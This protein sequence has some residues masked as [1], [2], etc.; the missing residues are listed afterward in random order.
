MDPASAK[1]F[2]SVGGNDSVLATRSRVRAVAAA[3]IE[4][5]GS[6][7]GA[8]ARREHL[9][10]VVVEL[11]QSDAK[12]ADRTEVA[13]MASRALVA[14]APKAGEV[15]RRTTQDVTS[16]RRSKTGV[17]SS[18][19]IAVEASVV[20]T[21]RPT[22]ASVDALSATLLREGYRVVVRER[23]ECRQAACAT[24]AIVE[25]NQLEEVPLGWCNNQICGLHCFKSCG[26]CK[27]VYLCTALNAAGKAPSVYCAVCE[28]VLIEWGASKVWTA[29]LV[30]RGG[31]A[32]AARHRLGRAGD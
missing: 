24:E 32:V 5:M 3:T 14:Y 26:N 12:N 30:T 6:K 28:A 31:D 22:A 18:V 17:M 8:T 10:K 7:V 2:M 20:W 29:E 21:G 23:R 25:W 9:V 19:V 4:P 27:S 1:K 11:N 15:D 16:T 13:A